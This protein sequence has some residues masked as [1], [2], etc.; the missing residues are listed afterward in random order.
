MQRDYIL[1]FCVLIQVCMRLRLTVGG[2]CTS[3][4]PRPRLPAAA[5]VCA[6][7]PGWLENRT[8]RPQHLR[9]ELQLVEQIQTTT[10]T[11]PQEIAAAR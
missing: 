9:I 2:V 7:A 4:S 8:P 3:I 6:A 5:L 11:A 1:L 10:P